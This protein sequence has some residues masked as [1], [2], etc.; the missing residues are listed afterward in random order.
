M[1]F[2]KLQEKLTGKFEIITPILFSK[3]TSQ[4]SFD[5]LYL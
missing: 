4:V 3:D 5:Q 1:F 2:K